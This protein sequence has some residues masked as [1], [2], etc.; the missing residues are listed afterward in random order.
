MFAL[1]ALVNSE[2]I[3]DSITGLVFE[4]TANHRFIVLFVR[5]YF[6]KARAI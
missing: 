1:S 3:N 6:A 5:F 4:F 2:S